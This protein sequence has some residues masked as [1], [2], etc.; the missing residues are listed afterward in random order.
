MLGYITCSLL[1]L[2]PMVVGNGC[3]GSSDGNKE[4]SGETTVTPKE[5]IPL[6]DPTIFEDQGTYYIYGTNDPKG[7]KVYQ[8]TDL[9]NWTGPD[10][11][12]DGLALAKG[13]SWGESGFWAPQVL[14]LDSTFCMIYTANEQ[15][16][17]AYST[18]PLGPFTQKTLA[19]IPASTKEIDPF[20]FIDDDGTRYLYHV[21]L[22]NGNK[23]YVAQMND[24]MTEMKEET[25]TLCISGTESYENTANSTWPV[26]EGPT[27]V[28]VEG[29]YYM[30]YS[31]N[32][33]RNINYCVCQAVADS[34]LGPWTKL[35]Q[36]ITHDKIGQ[37]GPG[38]GD[39]FKDN[40]GNWQYVFHTHFNS[41]TVA[42]RKSAIVQLKFEDGKFSMVDGTF[43]Y[44]M[45]DVKL[46]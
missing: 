5:Y 18:S 15:L 42:P 39:L 9:E 8:S 24:D 20:L 13:G 10:G 14:K 11:A 29:K 26:T 4:N 45:A 33:F 34:P 43:R 22:I 17:I 21:R 41:T 2:L 27:V 38:H 7:F 19:Q 1:L 25:A 30:F 37:N 32:D 31:A 12:T 35:G 23:I 6:A 44:L 16:A 28:K 3:K 36:M 40:D 46:N